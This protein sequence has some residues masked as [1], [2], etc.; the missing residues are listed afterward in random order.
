MYENQEYQID[1]IYLENK[2]LNQASYGL[3]CIDVFSKKADVELMK[4]KD[5]K[6][7]L[8]ALKNV[9]KRMNKPYSIYCDEGSEFTNKEFK[10]YCEDNDIELI[11]TLC[12]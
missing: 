3:C 9:I 12:F 7:T 8:E 5:E 4:R 10:K 2:H 1:L 6:S 11:I